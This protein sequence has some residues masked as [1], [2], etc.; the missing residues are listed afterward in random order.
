ML[1]PGG[2]L[3]QNCVNQG[4]GA[5]LQLASGS[6]SAYELA[7]RCSVLTKR[8]LLPALHTV[9]QSHAD[10]TWPP[11]VSASARAADD[12]RR[13][14]RMR[15]RMRNN[16][17]GYGALAASQVRSACAGQ[18]DTNPDAG[19][20]TGRHIQR[21]RHRQTPTVQRETH[22]HTQ[23]A[24]TRGVLRAQVRGA[25]SELDEY[26]D[27]RGGAAAAPREETG[28]GVGAAGCA[29]QHRAERH[30]RAAPACADAHVRR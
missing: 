2:L 15:L 5:T 8:M 29:E 30:Q 28:G 23:D 26:F 27:S 22:R 7:V 14:G 4:H 19:R 17:A 3:F 13:G 10:V 20:Q 25:G 12:A 9:D 6:L 11:H 21:H 18:T 1:L 16:T 24:Q